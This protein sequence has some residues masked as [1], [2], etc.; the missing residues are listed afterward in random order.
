MS[1]VLQ[2]NGFPKQFSKVIQLI[3]KRKVQEGL[4]E[5]ISN[6]RMEVVE[7]LVCCLKVILYK[8]KREKKKDLAST[9]QNG[10]RR[11]LILELRNKTWRVCAAYIPA[12]KN[13]GLTHNRQNN[14]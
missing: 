1:L 5:S 13:Y 8:T 2:R 12:S 11:I 9:V 4:L 7:W 14:V 10:H 3:N 6:C